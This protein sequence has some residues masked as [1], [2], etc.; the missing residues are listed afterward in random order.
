MVENSLRFKGMR[1]LFGGAPR[2]SIAYLNHAVT[3]DSRRA[4]EILAPVD[5]A[6]PRFGTYV[7]AMVS[8]FKENEERR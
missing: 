5:L 8:Y 4:I 6:P 1:E 7:S 2:E 3:F